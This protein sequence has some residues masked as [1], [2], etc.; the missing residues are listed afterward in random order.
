LVKEL[1]DE[2][3][4]ENLTS[5]QY[6]KDLIDAGEGEPDPKRAIQIF[7]LALRFQ[8]TSLYANSIYTGLGMK[9]EVLGDR[10]IAIENY[11]KAIEL[12]ASNARLFLW[13]GELF[14]QSGELGKAKSDFL[15]ALTISPNKPEHGGLFSD[16][17]ELVEKYLSEMWV[18]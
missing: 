4:E 1:I 14:K 7:H 12:N 3:E 6:V 5:S 9:Y 13:R 16:E 17:K 10:Q 15:Q 11:T 18:K 8:P 2:D